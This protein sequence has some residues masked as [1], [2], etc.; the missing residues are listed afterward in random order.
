METHNE[1]SK[2]KGIA[3]LTQKE[4]MA[5]ADTLKV[6]T[7]VISKSEYE[8]CTYQ[9]HYASKLILILCVAEVIASEKPVVTGEASPSDWAYP[10]A[11]QFFLDGHTDYNGP[12][13]LKPSAAITKIKKGNKAPKAPPLPSVDES[14]ND[15]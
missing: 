7:M 14:D 8:R 2:K 3:A 4:V 9:P 5:L 15:D 10:G 6:R 11:Q 12:D 13:R 1:I